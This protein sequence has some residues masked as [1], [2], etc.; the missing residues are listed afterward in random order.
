VQDCL[1]ARGKDGAAVAMSLRP[2]NQLF[3]QAVRLPAVVSSAGP[4]LVHGPLPAAE[5]QQQL[6]TQ[7]IAFHGLQVALIA[8]AGRLSPAA[9]ARACPRIA[10]AGL[11][12]CSVARRV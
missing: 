7:H 4:G 5:T 8:F 12:N 3:R 10:S 1:D 11:S 6:H 2:G 9:L